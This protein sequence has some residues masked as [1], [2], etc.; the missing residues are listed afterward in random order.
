[1]RYLFRGAFLSLILF[2]GTFALL[3]RVSLMSQELRL[4]AAY[5]SAGW[6]LAWLMP[7]WL[8]ANPTPPALRDVLVP[9]ILSQGAFSAFQRQLGLLACGWIGSLVLALFGLALP[10]QP[11]TSNTVLMLLLASFCN[12]L[13]GVAAARRLVARKA[14]QEAVLRRAWSH[15]SEQGA[16]S[17]ERARRQAWIASGNWSPWVGVTGAAAAGFAASELAGWD[18]SVSHALTDMGFGDATTSSSDGLSSADL[19]TGIDWTTGMNSSDS[20]SSSSGIFTEDFEINPAT[21]LP[22]I[23]GFGGVDVAGNLYGTDHSDL[24]SSHDFGSSSGDSSCSFSSSSDFD[25][26]SWDSGS[27]MFE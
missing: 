23:G 26:S 4:V 22:M 6:I 3:Q 5:L 15:W 2:F 8:R 10:L 21:G 27:S 16:S 1:M 12:V 19:S 24:S 11:K 20:F 17:D 18:D 13:L 14:G 7:I 25:S 9:A